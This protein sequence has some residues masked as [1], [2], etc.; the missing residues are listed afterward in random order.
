MVVLCA[1]FVAADLNMIDNRVFSVVL[2]LVV[3]Q[4]LFVRAVPQCDGDQL[5]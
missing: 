1:I 3:V 5:P 4:V 2:V